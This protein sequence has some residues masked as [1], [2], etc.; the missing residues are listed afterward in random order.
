MSFFIQIAG[1]NVLMEIIFLHFSEDKTTR[2]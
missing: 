2:L 1:E